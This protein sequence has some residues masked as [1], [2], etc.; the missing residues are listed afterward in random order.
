[1][2]EI[3]RLEPDSG[4]AGQAYPIRL[5]IHGRRFAASGNTVQFGPVVLADLPSTDGGTRIVASVPKVR[6][7]RGEVPP[8]ELLPGR[9]DVTVRTP[10]GS[11]NAVT[12]TLTRPSQ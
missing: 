10:A 3:T 8:F 12:F 7:A 6:P 11:S 4:P 1:M 2:P 9:Y 5:S